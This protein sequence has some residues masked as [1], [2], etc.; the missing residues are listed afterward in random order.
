M[1]AS[2]LG[3][4]LVNALELL[5]EKQTH[6]IGLSQLH[7]EK[8][9]AWKVIPR[10]AYMDGKEVCSVYRHKSSTKRMSHCIEFFIC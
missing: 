6:C 8:V 7:A 2:K 9:P 5:L 10:K 3:I 1:A 4:D